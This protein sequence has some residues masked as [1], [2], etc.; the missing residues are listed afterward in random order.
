MAEVEKPKYDIMI[1]A[2]KVVIFLGA[3][4][5]SSFIGALSVLPDSEWSVFLMS[6]NLDPK[7]LWFFTMIVLPAIRGSNNARKNS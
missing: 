6:L 3:I 4:M 7:V 5:W 2:K 1:T